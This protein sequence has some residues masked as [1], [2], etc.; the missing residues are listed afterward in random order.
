MGMGLAEQVLGCW[1]LAVS[2]WSF[3]RL[4]R[5]QLIINQLPIGR[6]KLVVS[7]G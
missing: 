2:G 1:S 3:Y 4:N 7:D 6:Q 5:K